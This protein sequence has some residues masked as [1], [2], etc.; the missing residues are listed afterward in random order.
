MSLHLLSYVLI[1]AFA[2]MACSLY[3]YEI[4][5]RKAKGNFKEFQIQAK[6]LSFLR[7][8]VSKNAKTHLYCLGLA[9]IRTD[10]YF[11]LNGEELM[12]PV[13]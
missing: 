3:V 5:S 2:L 12:E 6:K 8:S 13:H 7:T 11:V 1:L 10:A 9:N 4:Y